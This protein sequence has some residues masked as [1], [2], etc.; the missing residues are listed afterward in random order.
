MEEAADLAPARPDD[1][2]REREP[3]PG[4]QLPGRA[5]ERGGRNPELERG[6]C[7]ARTGRR[8][9]APPASRRGRRRTAADRSPSARRRLPPRTAAPPRDPSTRRTSLLAAASAMRR[10][11]SSS[12][13][14][15]W[16]I[17]T[18]EQPFCRTSSSATAPVPLATSTTTSPGR[19]SYPFDEE[20]APARVLPEREQPCV[21]VVGRA[22]RREEL[23]SRS[24]ARR[25]GLGH[26]NYSRKGGAP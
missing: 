24:R 17:P 5:R 10:R 4:I 7:A 18:T 26:R 15:L 8:A 16:S 14:A 19:A 13:S 11:A 1:P 9:R 6:Q 25:C 21:P 12:I 23:A 3:D 2:A 22:E 20:A